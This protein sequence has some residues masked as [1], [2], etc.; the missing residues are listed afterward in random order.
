MISTWS[1]SRHHEIKTFEVELPPGA[2]G[3][4][5][6]LPQV[7]RSVLILWH[8]QSTQLQRNSFQCFIL[9]H[10]PDTKALDLL[11][12]VFLGLQGSKE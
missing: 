4:E 2:T 5:C 3:R 1:R 9:P 8:T 11:T 7:L 12:G 10:C 6:H